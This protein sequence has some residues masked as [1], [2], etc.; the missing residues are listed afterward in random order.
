MTKTKSTGPPKGRKKK[1]VRSVIL[2]AIIN[3]VW[4]Y[5]L[6]WSNIYFVMNFILA[7]GNNIKFKDVLFSL[8]RFNYIYTDNHL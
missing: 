1:S 3:K 6:I 2:Q 5:F 8:N 4:M 7:I